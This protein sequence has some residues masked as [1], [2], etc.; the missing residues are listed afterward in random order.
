MASIQK[1]GDTYSCIFYWQNKRQWL[2]L[3]AVSEGEA[4]AKSAQ[5]K[6]LLMR[7]KQGWLELPLGIGIVEFLRF[8]GKPPAHA[9]ALA[10]GD[11]P[12]MPCLTLAAFRDSY[13]DT[14]RDSLE[15]RTVDTAELHFK[16][17]VR[18]LGAGFPIRDLKLA[19]LQKYADRR[20]REKTAAGN[21]ISP[22]TIRKEIVTLRT[23]WNWGVEME[24]VAGRYPS[25]GVRYAKTDE[26]PPFQTRQQIERKIAAGGLKPEQIRE[27]WHALYLQVHEI[28]A[29]LATV[30]AR[31]A[32]PW[33]YPLVCMA[34]HTGARRSELARMQVSDIDFAEGTVTIHEMKRVKGKRSTRTAPLTSLLK[35]ASREWLK[36][37]PGG[38][39]LFCH[40]VEVMRSKKRSLTTGHQS[41]PERA[42]SLKGRMVTVKHRTV[43]VAAGPLTTKEIHDHFKRTL[44]GT[45]WKVVR[46]LHVL[47]HSMISCLAAGGIDQ[48][49][50]DDIVG[51]CS[52]EM[53][54]RYRHLT[55]E[56]KQ[57]SVDAVFG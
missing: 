47:R 34:A 51:H 25:K 20:S 46:G 27:L 50:I 6:Y 17:L 13:F 52:E 5:I 3:G 30:R 32:H 12:A 40:A 19:S 21:R 1:R 7:L 29:F 16:H 26:K 4:E 49:F 2:S 28:A 55:P 39:A 31:A 9:D 43:S 48:R 54:R 56:V 37:H 11:A 44:S 45:D 35:E 53:R 8:D 41:G 23:A 33:I 10:E 18:I 22:V 15:A 36:I 24:L 38:Q 42:K 14:H 57:R